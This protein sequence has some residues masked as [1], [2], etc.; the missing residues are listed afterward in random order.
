MH[1][2]QAIA[3]LRFDPLIP[4][5]LLW[6]LAGLAGLVVAL[7][8]L[9]RA[10]GTVLRMAAFAALLLWLAGPR[11]TE[12]TRATLPDIGLLV[13]DRTASMGVGDRAKIA[14]AA[15]RKVET[16]AGQAPDL[17]LRTVVVPEGGGSGT[18]LFEA[19]GRAMT[20]IPRDRFAGTIAI[21]DGQVHD[22]PA[23]TASP[24]GEPLNVLIPAAGEQTDR[25]LRVLEAPSYGIVGK[26]VTLRVVVED[27]GVAHP[28]ATARLTVRRDGGPAETRTVPVGTPTTLQVPISRAGPSVV[29][30]S[31]D[32]L[33]GEVS[34]LNNTAVVQI[35]GVRDRLRVLL[36]SG[37]PHPGER[38]WRRLLKADP[39]V[40]LVHFTILR[41]P[42]KDDLTPLNE[43]SLIAF[44]V[45]ELFQD[46]IDQFDL[47]ILDRFQ[48]RGLLPLPY[49]D[50][51]AR[52]VRDGGALLLSVGPEFAGAATLASTP[53]A[54]V[55]PAVPAPAG[56]V[57][58]E[59]FRPRL[60]ALGERHPVTEGLTGANPPDSTAAPTWGSWYRRI[61]PADV[62]GQTLMAAPDG[63]PLLI[64]DQ[65]GKGR[66]A[67]LL[68]DQIWLWSRGHEGGGPQG[69]LLRRVAHWLMKEP[70]LEAEA[71][72]A[73]IIDG[74]LDIERRSTDPAP[75]PPVTVTAPDG[76]TTKLKLTPDAPGRAV[77]D[78]PAD[79]PG[80]WQAS[81]G[82]HTVQ[83][84]AGAANPLE[85]ED[86]RA[87]ATRLAP[88]A[89][90]SGGV[91]W[92]GEGADP[93]VP[94]LRRTEP[95]RTA[96]GNGWMGLQRRHAY[97][98][99]GVSSLPL[100]PAWIALPLLLGLLIL[101]WRR[102]EA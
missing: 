50:N 7:G 8:A 51:I 55:L 92:L 11:L 43:L 33:P 23:T 85:I 56:A 93:K 45:R 21:T 4:L 79:K 102:E 83:A 9:R 47:I 27:R 67:L 49:L 35:N 37:E 28:D 84:A 94:E 13:V 42:E 74:R 31:V 12:E 90:A 66:V 20:D 81:D 86:L 48:N 82:T 18:R 99:T 64:L 91:H 69:E 2:V 6:A 97:V 29:Q 87:T 73:H 53:L 24:G 62:R 65:E 80:V 78:M 88:L 98:V 77:A 17:Q 71:L 36:I 75:P 15:R 58:D 41:P 52:Y 40:D 32:Q 38:T 70:E 44:P 1:P 60:T 22:I 72:T 59:K 25:T 34:A 30:L 19:I 96:S 54:A 46:K 101:A 95:D 10:R 26:P 14:E 89:R 3:A 63:T 68:S 5:G 61:E 39:S 16:A 57:V 100:L 76:R